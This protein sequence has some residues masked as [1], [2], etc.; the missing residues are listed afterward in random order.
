MNRWQRVE[1]AAVR[2][3]VWSS[4]VGFCFGLWTTLAGLIFSQRVV[5][6]SGLV[7]AAGSVLAM[8]NVVAFD[9][10]WEANR[11]RRL[12]SFCSA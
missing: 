3:L 7:L 6:C 5:W 12:Y 4:M 2:M 8:V 11:A 1:T 9:V 10:V